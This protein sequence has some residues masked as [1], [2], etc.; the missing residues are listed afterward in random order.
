[1]GGMGSKP[2]SDLVAQRQAVS[3]L[4]ILHSLIRIV[5]VL[6]LFDE[7]SVGCGVVVINAS[8]KDL[9]IR[10]AVIL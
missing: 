9:V 2:V 1:M 7:R 5:T 3:I 4:V 6:V 8:D 10:R